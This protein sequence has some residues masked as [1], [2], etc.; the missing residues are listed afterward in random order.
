M[1]LPSPVG[2]VFDVLGIKDVFDALNNAYPR[3]QQLRF[4]GATV[5]D[6]PALG[7]TDVT[8]GFSMFRWVT[9]A[10]PAVN[11]D[12]FMS[13]S[14]ILSPNASETI[15]T[16][17]VPKSFTA[18]R[19]SF[20]CGLNALATDSVVATVRKNGVDTGIT[21]TVPPATAPGTIIT[22]ALHSVVFAAG[23][24]ISIKLRQSGAT[25]QA[26]WYGL[27]QVG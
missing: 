24:R 15:G 10:A 8:V 9:A 26:S 25:A 5:A 1:T 27:F 12:R 17:V 3:R 18:T 14:D 2:W 6:N 22:D 13:V 21:L 4:L 19:L 23:D 16:Y 7:T 11:A 20:I